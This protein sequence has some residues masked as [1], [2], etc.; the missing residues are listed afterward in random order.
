[1]ENLAQSIG[2]G[3]SALS[4]LAFTFIG[5]KLV[6]KL[7]PAKGFFGK[8]RNLGIGYILAI[9]VKSLVADKM[10]ESCVDTAEMSK[11]LVDLIDTQVKKVEE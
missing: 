9:T 7:A 11:K 3:Y 1:M 2:V 10:A 8:A 4:E 5:T 6:G